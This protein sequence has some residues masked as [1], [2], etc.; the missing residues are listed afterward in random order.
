[1]RGWTGA[2]GAPAE[3][4]DAPLRRARIAWMV[5]GLAAMA[6]AGLL[7]WLVTH[8]LLRRSAAERKA[9]ELESARETDA[10]LAEIARHFPGVMYRC[11]LHPDGRVSHPFVSAGIAVLLGRERDVLAEPRDLE[12]LAR[13]LVVEEDRQAARAALL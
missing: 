7:A 3:L 13:D 2:A 11:V 8:S 1:R 4:V 6:L 9:W 12:E 10:R 5:G